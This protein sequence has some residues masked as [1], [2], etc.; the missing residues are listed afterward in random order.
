[1]SISMFP[2]TL[3]FF[4]FSFVLR[5]FSFFFLLYSHLLNK[6]RD[7]FIFSLCVFVCGIVNVPTEKEDKRNEPKF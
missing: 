5:R 7:L 6:T 4:A 3:S 2:F 1:M